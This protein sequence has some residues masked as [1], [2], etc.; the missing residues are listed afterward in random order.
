MPVITRRAVT[1]ALAYGMFRKL[2]ASGTTVIVSFTAGS[3]SWLCPTGVTTADYL[4]GGGGGGGGGGGA[5][6]WQW[7]RW[8]VRVDSVL[9]Q[10]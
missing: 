1:S 10:V 8:L 9:V 4:V 7:R 5:G 6:P 2:S 3:G